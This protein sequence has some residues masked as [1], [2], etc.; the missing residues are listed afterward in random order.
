MSGGIRGCRG[1]V[2]VSETA[3]VEL[4]RGRVLAP[5]RRHPGANGHD[6]RGLHRAGL[7]GRHRGRAAAGG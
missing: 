2:L 5:A 4:T 6:G 7:D 1:C 3:Q